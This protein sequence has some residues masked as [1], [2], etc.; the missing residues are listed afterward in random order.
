MWPATEL[1]R[2]IALP[3]FHS[4]P[5][6]VFWPSNPGVCEAPRYCAQFRAI[7]LRALL[8]WGPQEGCGVK[9][10]PRYIPWLSNSD[11]LSRYFSITERSAIQKKECE[12]RALSSAWTQSGFFLQEPLPAALDMLDSSSWEFWWKLLAE[13][14][15]P[16]GEVRG[17]LLGAGGHWQ[18]KALLPPFIFQCLLISVYRWI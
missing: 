16:W 9:G 1:V 14:V 12:P 6:V 8:S 10:L 7:V 18:E 5:L 11:W 4:Q 17:G 2:F 13:C 3:H 15:P